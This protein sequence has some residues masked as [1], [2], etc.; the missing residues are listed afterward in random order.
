MLCVSCFECQ[1]P[2]TSYWFTRP[3]FVLQGSVCCSSTSFL[4]CVLSG[5]NDPCPSFFHEPQPPTEPP[6]SEMRKRLYLPFYF[7]AYAPRKSDHHTL[8]SRICIIIRAMYIYLS[9]WRQ[10]FHEF[11]LCG[12]H[13]YRMLSSWGTNVYM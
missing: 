10:P 13:E 5:S 3:A 8:I 7:F 9:L 2:M 12:F 4:F 1:F 11:C 6:H